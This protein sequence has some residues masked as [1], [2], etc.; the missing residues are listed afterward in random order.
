MFGDEIKSIYTVLLISHSCIHYGR[1]G[2]QSNYLINSLQCLS[3]SYIEIYVI[4]GIGVIKVYI[5]LVVMKHCVP[6]IIM[7]NTKW[8]SQT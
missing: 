3:F 8:H 6:E 7:T 5:S 4:N 2:H 1:V